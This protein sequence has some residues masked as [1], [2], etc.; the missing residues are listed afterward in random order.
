MSALLALLLGNP[1][2]LGIGAAIL[3]TLGWGL[4]QRFAG[5]RSERARQAAAEAAARDVADQV[6]NDIGALPAAAARKELKSWARD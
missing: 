3:A 5:G 2:I 6:Q 1:T 4:R